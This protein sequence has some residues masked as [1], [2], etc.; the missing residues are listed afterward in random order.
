[1]LILQYLNTALDFYS[2]KHVKYYSNE[3]WCMVSVIE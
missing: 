1:M 3:S 2:S